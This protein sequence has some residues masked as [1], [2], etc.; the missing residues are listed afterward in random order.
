MYKRQLQPN[1]GYLY[2]DDGSKILLADIPGIIEGAHDNRGLGFQFLRH[3]ERTKAL[4]YVLDAAGVDGRDPMQDMEVLRKELA[5]Y[6]APLTQKPYI[7][8]L[9]KC[10]MEEAALYIDAFMKQMK[11]EKNRVFVVS[12]ERGDGLE[13]LKEAVRGLLVL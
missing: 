13:A 2:F 1:L 5:A 10:D 8:V 6:D 3:I 9:N 7:V 4:I 11:K 12:A